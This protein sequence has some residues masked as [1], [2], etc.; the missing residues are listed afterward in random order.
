MS[1]LIQEN[2]FRVG[3]LFYGNYENEEDEKIESVVCKI[4]GYDS[5]DNFYQVENEGEIEEFCSIQKIPL[6]KEW[7]LKFGFDVFKFDN[8]EPNQYRF[9]EMLLVIRDGFFVDYG[10]SV[11]LEYLHE[12]QNL[13]YA[14]YKNELVIK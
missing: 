9:K 11:K 1:E 6:T 3:N 12:L 2:D 14:K 10:T 13:Y 7:L 5:F 8:G 4:L